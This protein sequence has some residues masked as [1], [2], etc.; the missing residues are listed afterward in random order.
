V[1]ILNVTQIAK[2]IEKLFNAGFD[3]DKLI[4]AMQLEDVQKIDGLT[5]QDINTIIKF[6]KAIRTR[7]IVK[8]LTGKEI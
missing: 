4:L 8:F 2:S 1:E 5:M 3:D 6:K 7:Q